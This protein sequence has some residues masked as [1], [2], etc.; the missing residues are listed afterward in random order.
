M[1]KKQTNSNENELDIDSITNNIH[2]A[3]NSETTVHSSASKGNNIKYISI[4]I[5]SFCASICIWR[6]QCFWHRSHSVTSRK[7]YSEDHA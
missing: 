2:Q 5:T 3:E 7:A 1:T 4:I 6:Y